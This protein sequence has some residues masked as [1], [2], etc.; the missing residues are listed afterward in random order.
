MAPSSSSTRKAARLAQKGKR[1]RVR[2][3]GGT[4]F[5]LVV[6]LVLVLGLGLVVYARASRPEDVPP[7]VGS[8][9]HWHAAYAFQLCSDSANV[10]LTGTLEELDV[11]GRL[12]GS[13]DYI[14][15]GVHSHDDG[16]IHWH[17][18]GSRATGRNAKLEVFFENYDIEI[19]NDR[20]ELPGGAF[21]VDGGPPPEGYPTVYEEGETE[22]TGEDAELRVVVWDDASDP[23][24]SQTYVS[25]FGNIP[26][27]DDGKAITIAFVP[28]DV[29]IVRPPTAANLEQ[30]GAVDQPTPEP[31][32]TLPSAETS[33][34][35]DS[36]VV[37]GSTEPEPDDTE[38][39]E[40]TPGTTEADDTE[41][42]AV[43]DTTEG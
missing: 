14:T 30:L 40:T 33:E 25:S 2:F 42:T 35:T 6:A 43:T 15:S 28:D 20:L 1:K 26:F 22:C 16:L 24:S 19:S 4:L 34:P 31:G 41:T 9:D 39:D 38:P 12:I 29:E 3:Q 10:V 23:G 37:P 18:R 13:Q 11:D 21:T 5:P 7:H 36:T 32:E 8:I 27:D 17:A